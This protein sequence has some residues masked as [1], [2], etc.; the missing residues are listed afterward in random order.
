VATRRHFTQKYKDQAVSLV[1]NSGR[2][3]APTYHHRQVVVR[4]IGGR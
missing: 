3:T 2:T 1:L 4:A